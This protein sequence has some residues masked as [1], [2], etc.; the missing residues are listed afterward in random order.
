M[1]WSVYENEGKRH[2]IPT[3]EI[4]VHCFERCWC[5]PT[6]SDVDEDVLVHKSRDGR[7]D[8]ENGVRKRS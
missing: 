5:E 2:V 1:T 3:D 6:E 7:E 4:D 8:F